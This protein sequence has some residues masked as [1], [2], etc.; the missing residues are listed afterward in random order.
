MTAR[1]RRSA[2]GPPRR[3]HS[4]APRCER[5]RGWRP[6]GACCARAGRS[7]R[8]SPRT[9]RGGS[10][11]AT[12]IAARS[13]PMRSRSPG[14]TSDSSHDTLSSSVTSIGA[15]SR[16]ARHATSGSAAGTGVASSTVAA[17][18]RAVAAVERG[19]AQPAAVAV[20]IAVAIGEQAQPGRR[21]HL[22]QRQRLGE[23]GQ[24]RQQR[25]AASRLVGLRP[26]RP[27]ELERLGP[28]VEEPLAKLRPVAREISVQVADGGEQQVGLAL[29]RLELA[30]DRQEL[31]VIRDLTGQ[32]ACRAPSGRPSPPR[33][34]A[35][36]RPPVDRCGLRPRLHPA[37]SPG[38]PQGAGTRRSRPP[39][40]SAPSVRRR[41]AAGRRCGGDARR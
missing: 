37:R 36:T 31:A 34:S 15:R 33:R 16:P 27:D 38:A 21:P 6:A 7:W 25:G 3:G 32:L 10:A 12:A 9:T 39:D 5:P 14:H 22:Q 17:E 1:C 24:H 40:G 30:Q 41:R 23:G 11:R 26:V 19:R 4:R 28:A 20:V 13:G 29:G 35:G 8:R 18:H 2:G